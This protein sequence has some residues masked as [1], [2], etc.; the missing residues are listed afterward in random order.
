VSAE[1]APWKLKA[2]AGEDLSGEVIRKYFVPDQVKFAK[3]DSRQVTFVISTAAIDR[4]GDTIAVEGWDVE[5]YLKNPVV[6]WAHRYDQLP[7]AK[8]VSVVKSSGQLKATAEFPEPGINPL[9][10]TVFEMLRGGFLRATSVG[11]RPKKSVHNEERPG[12]AM[13]FIEQELLE[14]SVVPVPANPEALMEAAKG[15]A[16]AIGAGIDLSP[17]EKALALAK[18][19]AKDFAAI[20]AAANG[21]ASAFLAMQEQ[22]DRIQAVELVSTVESTVDDDVITVEVKGDTTPALVA[23]IESLNAVLRSGRTFS[24]ANAKR[25]KDAHEACDKVMGHLKELVDQVTP[26]DP[27][28]DEE[29]SDKGLDPPEPMPTEPSKP[30]DP[31]PTTYVMTAADLTASVEAAMSKA[32]AGAPAHGKKE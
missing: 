7:V 3:D 28:E 23:A 25:I 2:K 9:A 13:D 17:L 19:V 22:L 16:G 21:A 27:D 20:P 14:F 29:E 10:D 12:W 32:K 8:A 6:L 26:E 31:G 11:F 1:L 15:F 4:E 30:A 5:N 24:A 18:A